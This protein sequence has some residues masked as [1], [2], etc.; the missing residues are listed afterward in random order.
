MEKGGV[1]KG[2]TGD[3]TA[4]IPSLSHAPPGA[5]SSQVLMFVSGFLWPTGLYYSCFTREENGSR[6]GMGFINLLGQ[7]HVKR[8]SGSIGLRLEETPTL[9]HSCSAGSPQSKSQS[10]ALS[11]PLPESVLS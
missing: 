5:H 9:P 10:L 8:G 11:K 1:D 3:G 7:S 2:K 6:E 4:M